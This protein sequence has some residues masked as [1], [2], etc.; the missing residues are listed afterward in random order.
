MRHLA[1]LATNIKKG[2]ENKN[3]VL[4]NPKKAHENIKKSFS[5]T[6][7]DSKAPSKNTTVDAFE[8][9]M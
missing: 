1:C 5:I 7:H 9:L 8:N 3:N 2:Y 4:K 6:K